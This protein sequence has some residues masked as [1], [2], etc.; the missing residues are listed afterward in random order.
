MRITNIFKTIL[1]YLN[2]FS[3]SLAG[4]TRKL[5]LYLSIMGYTWRLDRII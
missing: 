3:E 4:T 5:I 2:V 1:S